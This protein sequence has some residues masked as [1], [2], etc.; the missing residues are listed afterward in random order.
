MDGL[1]ASCVPC[2]Q[3]S[4]SFPVQTELSAMKPEV[5]GGG[6]SLRQLR[7]LGSYAAATLTAPVA[8]GLP[9]ESSAVCWSRP[10]TSICFPVQTLVRALNS[11]VIGAGGSDCQ[12]VAATSARASLMVSMAGASSRPLK[13]R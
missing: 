1:Y 2:P 10:K 12:P 9:W 11:G 5:F 8:Y 6:A 13:R 4:I 3:T 7:D